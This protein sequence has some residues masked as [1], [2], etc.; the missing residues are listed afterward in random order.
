MKLDIKSLFVGFALGLV[1]AVLFF[2]LVGSVNFETE[3]QF[4][5]NEFLKDIK[6]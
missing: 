6:V 5:S 1:L 2:L 3:I 4:G